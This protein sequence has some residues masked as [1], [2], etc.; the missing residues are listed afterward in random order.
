[1][2]TGSDTLKRRA[3]SIRG[4]NTSSSCGTITVVEKETPGGDQPGGG[5]EPGDDQDDAGIDRNL[6]IGLGAV[7]VGAAAVLGSR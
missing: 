4:S 2:R 5:E 6:L 7:G 3:R 1:M